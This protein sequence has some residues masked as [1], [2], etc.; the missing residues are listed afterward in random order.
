MSLG[1]G[2]DRAHVLA[3][4]GLVEGATSQYSSQISAQRQLDH[5]SQCRV[6]F[7]GGTAVANCSALRKMKIRI[8]HR[9]ALAEEIARSLAASERP[10]VLSCP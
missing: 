8:C 3:Q 2:A 6:R 10:N 7:D 1:V 9:F 4:P 5:C